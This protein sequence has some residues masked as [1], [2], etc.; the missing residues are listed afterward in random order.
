MPTNAKIYLGAVIA[1]G[2]G[3]AA[4]AFSQWSPANLELFLIYLGAALVA[5]LCKLRLPGIDGT[6]SLNFLFILIG[7]LRFSLAETLL[8]GCGAAVVQTVLLT[9]KRPQAIQTAFNVADLAV[10]IGLCFALLQ[11]LLAGV[12]E[13]FPAVALAAAAA[14]YF[15][16]NTMLVSSVLSLLQGKALRA[17]SREWYVWSF[18]Y[19]L[20]GAALVGLLLAPRPVSPYAWLILAPMLYLVHFF[21]GL[22]LGDFST[23][24]AAK[25]ESGKKNLS[26]AAKLYLGM[27]ITAGLGVLIWNAFHWA[28]DDIGRFGAYLAAAVIL[29][30]CKVRLPGMTSTISLNFVVV[31]AAIVE[32]SL[33]EVVGLVAASAIVQSVWRPKVAPQPVQIAFSAA[34]IVLSSSFTFQVCHA[35]LEAP[36]GTLLVPFLFLA[37]AVLY[38]GNVVQ[39]AAAL[40][41][42]EGRP[43]E[44]M[45]ELCC[46]WTL[47]YYFTGTAFAGLMVAAA[48]TVDWPASFLTLPLLMLIYVS[49]RIHV[50]RADAMDAAAVR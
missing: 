49:Y 36:S 20:I 10:S 48:Q 6:Y 41:L 1:S 21:Y 40:C 2:T 3:V 32:L 25:L 35:A 26:T 17:V 22:S 50:R 8:V 13:T 45:W 30:C 9:K 15:F 47:P 4:V 43:I 7:L 39:V 31:L 18:P 46:F 29:S 12:L 28:T 16:V 37:T 38:S 33:P 23:K 44:K 14:V 5:S 27:V 19:Y 42:V 24:G 11:T 34:S